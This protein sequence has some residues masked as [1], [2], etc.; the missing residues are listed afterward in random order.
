MPSTRAW[1]W[2][3]LCGSLY[4]SPM[5]TAHREVSSLALCS[6]DGEAASGCAEGRRVQLQAR[7]FHSGIS[8]HWRVCIQGHQGLGCVPGRWIFSA[9][10]ISFKMAGV[11][12][13]S[14]QSLLAMELWSTCGWRR[15][16]SKDYLINSL[17]FR[18]LCAFYS[19]QLSSVSF[20][21]VSVF[22]RVHVRYP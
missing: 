15:L 20:V 7:L 10:F 5:P 18:D 17:F 2:D 14:S 16:A 22:V 21:N 8:R 13:S 11:Y 19:E 3:S 12:C 1:R 9:C 6:E 4:R